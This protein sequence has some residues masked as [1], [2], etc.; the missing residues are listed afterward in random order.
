MQPLPHR[1]HCKSFP[2]RSFEAKFEEINRWFLECS[3]GFIGTKL[4]ELQNHM[5]HNH[6][7]VLCV[8]EMHRTVSEY[9]IT[10]GGCLVLFSYIVWRGRWLFRRSWFHSC[11][12]LPALSVFIVNLVAKLPWN[13]EFLVGK[14]K[15]AAFTRHIVANHLMKG[16]RFF[17][18]LQVGWIHFFV[19]FVMVFAG[20]GWFQCSTSQNACG[21]IAFHWPTHFWQQ[22]CVF[23]CRIE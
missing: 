11:S 17:K 22:K 3:E 18:Q 23:Q 9:Y 12:T 4:E 20:V 14:W 16:K 1:I 21:R 13:F 6:I 19:I 7:G 8:Q 2:R 5:F 10:D 15:F